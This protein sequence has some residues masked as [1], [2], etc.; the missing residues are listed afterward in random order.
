MLSSTAYRL[1]PTDFPRGGGPG[2]GKPFT[3]SP[4]GGEEL[5]Y[6]IELWDD[7]KKRIELIL[8]AT[9]SPSIGYAAYYAAKKEHPHRYITLRH[10]G[11]VIGS[12]NG[13]AR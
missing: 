12:W 6:R 4:F 10:R 8:A 7:A 1:V 2:F 3:V 11:G 9:A 5:P 13:P